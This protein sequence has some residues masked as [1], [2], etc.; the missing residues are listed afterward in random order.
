MNMKAKRF[1]LI[2]TGLLLV[3]E[4]FSQSSNMRERSETWLQ[5]TSAANENPGPGGGR[6]GG[7][8]ATQE[9][10]AIP[11]GEGLFCIALCAG[12]YGWCKRN[13][14]A[15]KVNIRLKAGKI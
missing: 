11:V 9:D 10:P 7:T 6:T 1:L 8:T 14:K 12:V 15:N 4:L 3:C 2:L 13:G 5:R